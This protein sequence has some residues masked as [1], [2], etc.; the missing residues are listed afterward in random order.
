MSGSIASRQRRF[1]AIADSD[2][3]VK[4]SAA[5]LGGVHCADVRI[6]LVRTPLTVSAEQERA[7]LVGSGLSEADVER[8]NY[9][10]LAERLTLMD[11]D[12]VFV[13][14]RGPFV[15]LTMRQVD[16]LVKR[17]VVVTGM[18]GMSIPAQRAAL[19]YRRCADLFLVHSKR[20]RRAFTDLAEHMRVT[21]R[22]GLASLPYARAYPGEG[23]GTGTDIV[24]AA[25]AIVPRKLEE[26]VYLAE[27]LRRTALAHPDRRVI[28]KLRS[29]QDAG[30]LETHHVEDSFPE[31]LS[32]LGALPSNIVYSHD[33]MTNAL[34]GAKGLV[35]VSSSAA[36][37]AL[38]MGVPVIALDT[39]GVSK[40]N[41][42]TVF[43]GSGLLA[44]EDELLLLRF[45]LPTSQWAKRNYFHSE[46]K[47]TWLSDVDYLIDERRAGRLLIPV[48]PRRMGDALRHAW[49]R[50]SMLG[51][52]DRSASGA[53]ALALGVPLRAV[54]LRLRARRS[55][56]GQYSWSESDS[57]FTLTPSPTTEPLLREKAKVKSPVRV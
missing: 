35:T 7:A 28:V 15:R 12:A 50:K 44:G 18:P 39:F 21:M 1:V 43:A 8:V 42:N 20:E 49:D 45:R 33:S 51:S 55:S 37:E 54:A 3:Y 40:L 48:A 30:E 6:L 53:I 4:W 47:S 14:G 34:S 41:L 16:R 19:H 38:A 17:P 52:V 27:I 9:E 2:S 32:S 56:A 36:I 57:D 5:L 25:Q 22:F 10:N 23:A 29:R 26:R 11:A 24:F 31:L 46:A 13:A